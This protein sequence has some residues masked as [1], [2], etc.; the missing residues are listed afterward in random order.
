MKRKYLIILILVIF[1]IF[2]FAL[3]YKTL[4]YYEYVDNTFNN[5]KKAEIATKKIKEARSINKNGIK[6][7]IF[8][9]DTSSTTIILR[10]RNQSVDPENSIELFK[11]PNN[12]SIIESVERSIYSKKLSFKSTINDAGISKFISQSLEDKIYPAKDALYKISNNNIVILK[13]TN[14]V[15]INVEKILEQINCRLTEINTKDIDVYALAIEPNIKSEYLENNKDFAYKL[16]KWKGLRVEYKGIKAL[17]SGRFF[18]PLIM[19]D[20]NN[21]ISIDQT[22]LRSALRPYYNSYIDKPSVSPIFKIDKNNIEVKSPG[23]IGHDIKTSSLSKS[24]IE[25]LEKNI[26]SNEDLSKLPITKHRLEEE[27]Q[28]PILTLNKIKLLGINSILG[29]A[30]ISFAGSSKNRIHNIKLGAERVT[31]TLLE[32]GEEFSLVSTIG[33][34][35]TST[36]FKEEYVI[37]EN[38]S[39]KEAGGGLCQIATTFFRAT[40]DAGLRVL[41]RHNHRYIVSYYGPG[42]DAGIYDINHDFRFVNDT[43]NPILLQAYTE[44]QNMIVEIFGKHDGRKSITSKPYL[45]N[46]INPPRSEYYFSKNIN[47]GK[48]ECT[49]RA[50]KGVSAYATTTITYADN[51][52][53]VRVWRSKYVPWPKICLIGTKGLDI[54]QVNDE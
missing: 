49:D 45:Y 30:S 17:L 18:V 44:N 22:G 52:K 23:L 20:G 35:S 25:I 39:K 15:E 43:N 34:T 13:H 54:F 42:L 1:C 5:T 28:E 41:E 4:G 7:N 36:G 6:I 24:I 27:S 37:Q 14:G 50:R 21:I 26:N 51:T 10:E 8:F 32:P 11:L 47:F 16:L 33:Y 2:I 19:I 29:K 40:L 38:M 53:T 3:S 31:G 48:T 9:P 46:E 12:L